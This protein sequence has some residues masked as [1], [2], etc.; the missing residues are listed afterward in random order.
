MNLPNIRVAGKWCLFVP[1]LCIRFRISKHLVPV[2]G[3]SSLNQVCLVS[4]LP[5]CG[6]T[7]TLFMLDLCEVL[8]L[9]T[10]ITR[11][12]K[13]FKIRMENAISSAKCEVAFLRIRAQRCQLFVYTLT[14]RRPRCMNLFWHGDIMLKKKLEN[15]I[16]GSH[17]IISAMTI[18]TGKRDFSIS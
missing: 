13:I 6:A 15:S 12:Y 17:L 8:L 14:R 7:C 4:N 2:I 10:F 5:R 1:C 16:L 9:L 11:N 3:G 18:S